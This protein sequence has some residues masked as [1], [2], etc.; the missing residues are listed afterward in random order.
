MR[1]T[2]G[3]GGVRSTFLSLW[4][5][6]RNITAQ[7]KSQV[8]EIRIGNGELVIDNGELAFLTSL[9]LMTGAS[10]FPFRSVRPGYLEA[11]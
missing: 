10:N 5:L 8:Q 1:S 2:P 3:G 6:S 7:K 4:V 9:R 11:I